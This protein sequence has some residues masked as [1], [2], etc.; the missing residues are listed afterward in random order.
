[1]DMNDLLKNLGS[2]GIL[3]NPG[4]SE[5]LGSMLK[6]GGAGGL[7]SIALIALAAIFLLGSGG[8]DQ[9]SCSC[10][11]CRRHKHHHKRRCC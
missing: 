7:G 1:M 11:R 10:K 4:T 9:C 5:F 8:N 6:S 3:D 2:S